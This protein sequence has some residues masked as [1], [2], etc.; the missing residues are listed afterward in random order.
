MKTLLYFLLFISFY[1]ALYISFQ[2]MWKN[3]NS[4]EGVGSRAV[5]VGVSGVRG[6]S[7]YSK[8]GLLGLFFRK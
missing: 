8:Q 2:K 6:S 4:R 1:F 7:G 3:V 5:G